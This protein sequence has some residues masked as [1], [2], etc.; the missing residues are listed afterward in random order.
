[1]AVYRSQL[2]LKQAITDLEVKQKME[3]TLLVNEFNAT[4]RSFK[5]INIVKSTL[6]DV[7]NLPDLKQRLISTGIGLL[8]GYLSKK[9]VLGDPKNPVSKVIGAVLQ[10]GVSSLVSGKIDKSVDMNNANESDQNVNIG[11]L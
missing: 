2:Q 4:Y 8:A 5:P 7:V 9:V 3:W 1:M 6:A 10:F 11:S